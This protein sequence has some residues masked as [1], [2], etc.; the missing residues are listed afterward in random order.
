YDITSLFG[1]ADAT[2]EIHD[3]QF[4]NPGRPMTIQAAI[5]IQG[6]RALISGGE[7]RGGHSSASGSVPHPLG[8]VQITDGGEL[9]LRDVK[10]VDYAAGVRAINATCDA[11]NVTFEHVASKWD[12]DPSSR[13][14]SDGQ[15]APNSYGSYGQP[16]NNGYGY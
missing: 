6:G 16:M 13:I 7:I 1:V 3:C 14:T 5:A 15:A 9:T 2:C 12:Y 10:I 4:Y 8:A 11:T